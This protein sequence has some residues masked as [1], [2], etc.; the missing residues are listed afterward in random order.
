VAL[1]DGSTALLF[2]GLAF[3]IYAPALAAGFI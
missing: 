2:A 1:G 3:L